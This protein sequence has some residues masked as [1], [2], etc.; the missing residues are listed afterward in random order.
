MLSTLQSPI[1]IYVFHSDL[2]NPS[3]CIKTDSHITKNGFH[4]PFMVRFGS[5]SFS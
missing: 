3:H 2:E 1:I 5:E 4:F